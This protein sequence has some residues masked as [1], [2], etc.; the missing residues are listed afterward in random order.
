MRAEYVELKESKRK[1][2]SV[3]S[4]VFE[5]ALD[6]GLHEQKNDKAKNK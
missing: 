1:Y 4:G 2:L 5:K 3:E 6:V